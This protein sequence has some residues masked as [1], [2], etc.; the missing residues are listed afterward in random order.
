MNT[1][2]VKRLRRA[3]RIRRRIRLLDVTRL[4]VHRTPQHIYAQIIDKTGG[5][6]LASASTLEVEVRGQIKH[7]GNVEAAKLIGKRIA[8]KARSAGITNVAFDRSGYQ[9]HGR[10]KALADAAREAGLQL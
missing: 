9:Y 6:V 1:K 10:I 4:C 7:G 3:G 8:E 2:T 5:K